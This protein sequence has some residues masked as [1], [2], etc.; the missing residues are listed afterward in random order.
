MTGGSSMLAMIW[1]V[2]PHFGQVSTSIRNTR[3]RRFAQRIAYRCSAGVRSS[4]GCGRLGLPP[5]P[6]RAGVIRAL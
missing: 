2:P 3:L 1:T 6:R 4:N 5:R